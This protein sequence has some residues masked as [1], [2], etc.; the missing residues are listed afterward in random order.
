V[1]SWWILFVTDEGIGYS[2]LCGNG[3]ERNVYSNAVRF[4]KAGMS[5]RTWPKPY[6]HR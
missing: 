3:P 2:R 1:F 6:H 4:I 5:S